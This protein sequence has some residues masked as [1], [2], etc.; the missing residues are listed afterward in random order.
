[1]TKTQLRKKIALL[2]T[3]N[4]YLQTEVD[5][6]DQLM[7]LVGFSEGIKTVKQT[8]QEMI[9]QNSNTHYEETDN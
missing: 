6:I 7:T 4:D 2:E 8:A 9:K 1:M 3:L 5:Y